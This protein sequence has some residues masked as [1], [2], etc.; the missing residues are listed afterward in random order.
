MVNGFPRLVQVNRCHLIRCQYS[1]A[2]SHSDFGG[3]IKKLRVGVVGVGYLGQHHVRLYSTLHD[4]TLV[5]VDDADLTGTQAIPFET[6][7]LT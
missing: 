7:A 6:R 3:N 1:N 5:G 2:S 4:A